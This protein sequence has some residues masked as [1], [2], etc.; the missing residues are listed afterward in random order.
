MLDEIAKPTDFG[1][2]RRLGRK[3]DKGGD[4]WEGIQTTVTPSYL[5][6]TRYFVGENLGVFEVLHA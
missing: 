5:R 1:R 6:V 2:S 3:T 4:I